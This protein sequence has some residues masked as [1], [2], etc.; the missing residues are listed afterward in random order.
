MFPKKENGFTIEE[1]IQEI[2]KLFANMKLS[3]AKNYNY[4]ISGSLI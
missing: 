2:S 1:S 4:E 3:L